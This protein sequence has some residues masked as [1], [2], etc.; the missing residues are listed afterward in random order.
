MKRCA[1]LLMILLLALSFALTSQ[2]AYYPVSARLESSLSTRS[3]P[4]TDYNELGTY[5][6]NSWKNTTVT[7]YSKAYYNGIWWVQIEFTYNGTLYRAY[8]GEKRLNVNSD[9]LAEE[10]QLGTAQVMTGTAVQAYTGPGTNYKATTYKVPS[11]VSLTV[12]DT[13]NGF[14]QVDYLDSVTFFRHRCWVPLNQ[15]SYSGFTPDERSYPYTPTPTPTPTPYERG[16]NDWGNPDWSNDDWGMPDS[17]SGSYTGDVNYVEGETF[18]WTASDDTGFVV[19]SGVDLN[20]CAIIEL[21]ILGE[22]TYHNV[23]LYM[24]S[25]STGNFITIDGREGKLTF[26]DTYAIL[27]MD[28]RFAGIGSEFI[29][30]KY[31]GNE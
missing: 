13:E 5:F 27:R 30:Y 2:A 24:D 6:P 23:Y 21:T 28:L 29:M 7:A 4:S 1:M 11:A 9:Y 3:G 16:N 20:G 19:T 8:T 10:R 17:G 18:L 14:A 31:D 25:A 22:I 15:L 26:Y 12:Y